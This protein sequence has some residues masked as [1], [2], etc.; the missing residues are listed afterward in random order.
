MEIVRIIGVG[1]I[2]LIII[3]MLKQFR[4]EYT[5]YVSI[6]AGV[7]ILIMLTDRLMGI[8]GLINEIIK[9]QK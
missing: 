8:I 3:I 2:A 5:I 7:L 9:N 1:L 4:P 6:V